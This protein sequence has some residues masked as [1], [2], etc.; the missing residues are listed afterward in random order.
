L[1]PADETVM[2]LHSSEEKGLSLF[3]SSVAGNFDTMVGNWTTEF[4]TD[5]IV[6]FNEAYS[7]Q[8]SR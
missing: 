6:I 4:F 7:T 1:E 3:V 8:C 2:L 5:N